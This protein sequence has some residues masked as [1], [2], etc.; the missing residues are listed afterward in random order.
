MTAATVIRLQF[1]SFYLYLSWTSQYECHQHTELFMYSATNNWPKKKKNSPHM[2][3]SRP[4]L[5]TDGTRVQ[6]GHEVVASLFILS[7]IM[8]QQNSLSQEPA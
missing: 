8:R 7:T 1:S 3:E 4:H 6:Q 5:N 2:H